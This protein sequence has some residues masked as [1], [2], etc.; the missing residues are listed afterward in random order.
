MILQKVKRER[1]RELEASGAAANVGALAPV[2][3]SAGHACY[4]ARG[5]VACRMS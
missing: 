2:T 5:G 4:N 1:E 3:L